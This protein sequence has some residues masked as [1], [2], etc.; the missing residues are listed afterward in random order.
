[1]ATQVDGNYI[2]AEAGADLSAKQYYICKLDTNGKA[3]LAAAGTD[4]ISGTLATV[5][6]N[7]NGVVSIK[8][9]SASGTG[10]VIAG[11]SISKGA[12]L[13]SDGNGKAV[14]TTTAA[15]RVFGRARTAA[16][17]G[18]IFEYECFSGFMHA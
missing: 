15:D 14:A 12:Y 5:P 13:T 8:H 7:A 10:K 18:D 4:E 3:V 2:S 1:M 17:A 9:I 16:A 6:Q 11:G